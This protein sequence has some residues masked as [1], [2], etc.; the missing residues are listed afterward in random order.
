[1]IIITA[2][3]YDKFYCSA[4]KNKITQIIGSV[5]FE[6]LYTTQIQKKLD[7]WIKQHRLEQRN[8]SLFLAD[9]R[10]VSLKP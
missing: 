1:M 5:A 4:A 3:I 2:N 8:D 10:V 7:D 6:E 9:V